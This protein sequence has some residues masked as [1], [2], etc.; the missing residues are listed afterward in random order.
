MELSD[1]ASR[2]DSSI[3]WLAAIGDE[4]CLSFIE[5]VGPSAIYAWNR[6]L[7]ATLR[8]VLADAGV[9][10][11][12]LPAANQSHIVAIPLG[13]RD[14]A[15]VLAGTQ[16]VRRHL[17]GPGREPPDVAAFLQQPG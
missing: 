3:S 6:D 11:L 17:L 12:E 8:H 10:V 7:A 16:V 4:V 13:G 2:F 1:T 9:S 15:P 14:S 5:E